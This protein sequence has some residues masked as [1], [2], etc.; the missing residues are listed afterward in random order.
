MIC[1]LAPLIFYF[2]VLWLARLRYFH[3]SGL[4]FRPLKIGSMIS[5]CVYSQD[6]VELVTGVTL[7]RFQPF[8]SKENLSQTEN[9]DFIYE[10][11]LLNKK[12]ESQNVMWSYTGHV[13]SYRSWYTVK[14]W[15]TVHQVLDL[16]YSVQSSQ[17]GLLTP[18]F[19]DSGLYLFSGCPISL[20]SFVEHVVSSP[21]SKAVKFLPEQTG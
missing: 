7:K 2:R 1:I 20:G 17:S 3:P 12:I 10:K 15:I 11:Y 4:Q 8:T 6:I 9:I 18:S 19:P 21:Q 5:E 14:S 16:L 13:I